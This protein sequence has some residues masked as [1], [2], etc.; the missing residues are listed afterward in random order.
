MLPCMKKNPLTSAATH[1]LMYSLLS[2]DARFWSMSVQA[3]WLVYSLAPVVSSM[4]SWSKQGVPI[5]AKSTAYLC[6]SARTHGSW[7]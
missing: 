7:R 1:S 4:N 6:Q 5:S 2:E 3:M